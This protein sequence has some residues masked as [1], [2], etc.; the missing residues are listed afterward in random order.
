[1]VSAF[2]RVVDDIMAGREA[3]VAELVALTEGHREREAAFRSK[4]WR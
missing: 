4:T 3:G 1:V 2:R